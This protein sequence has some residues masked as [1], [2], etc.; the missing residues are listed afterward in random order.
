MKSAS[1]DS[2]LISKPRQGA[3]GPVEPDVV[4]ANVLVRSDSC[5]KAPRRVAD[6]MGSV[7]TTKSQ[8]VHHDA[9]E[10]VL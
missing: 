5:P 6:M 2:E 3:V 7:Q 9:C 4:E 10:G 8:N 1:V